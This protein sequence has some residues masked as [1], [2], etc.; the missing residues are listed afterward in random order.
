[1]T[2]AQR[3]QLARSY[4]LRFGWNAMSYQILNPGINLWFSSSKEAVAGYVDFAGYRI[5]AGAPV[6][7]SDQLDAVS[8]ELESDAKR[9][10][11][12]VCYFGAQDR[13]WD[14]LRSRC[15]ASA[16]LL[17]AQPVWK[18]AD[19]PAIV[20][21]K[22]SLRAQLSRARHKGVSIERWPADRATRN[23]QLESLLTRW[24]ATRGLPPMRFLV[25]PQ[26]LEHMDDRIV[27][28]AADPRRPGP[29]KPCGFLVA[30]PIPLRQGWLI[31]Q[32]VRD[33]DAPNGTTE[34]LLHTAV[35]ELALLDAKYV[36]LGLSPLSLRAGGKREPAPL[37][38]RAALAW[39]RAY[40]RRFYN[41][42][43]LDQF[44]AKFLPQ[45]WEPV[46]AATPRPQVTPGMLY[47]IAGAFG[48]QSPIR[49][50][51]RGLIRAARHEAGWALERF[52]GAG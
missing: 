29:D 33:D 24:L 42:D 5:V 31:E 4:V 14:L 45:R 50:V 10:L 47:A 52:A 34:L 25:E 35:L 26:T 20:G 27:F 8:R 6:C 48:G 15:P 22:S 7:A 23:V 12:T 30:T 39:I 3:L 2:P 16:I 21:S 46:Y 13:L 43:G 11:L 17:G 18:P 40:G 36:T 51:A 37:W 1:M 44:K 38:V 32:I 9:R 28:V 41:F 19:W 49:F